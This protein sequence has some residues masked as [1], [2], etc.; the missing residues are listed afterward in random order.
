MKFSHFPKCVD[1]IFLIISFLFLEHLVF[2]KYFPSLI[3]I[4]YMNC[5]FWKET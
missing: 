1:F 2:Y 5:F 3:N 4:I